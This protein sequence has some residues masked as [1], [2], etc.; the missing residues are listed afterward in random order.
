MFQEADPLTIRAIDKELFEGRNG[1]WRGRNAV[2]GKNEQPPAEGSPDHRL[3]VHDSQM[4][5]DV[6]SSLV[7][8]ELPARPNPEG[9]CS[10]H[11]DFQD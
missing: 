8:A 10:R 9:V 11:A 7:L 2:S 3:H 4:F 6:I 1:P 5:R